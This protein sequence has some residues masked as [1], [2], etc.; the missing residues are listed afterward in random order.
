ML[1]FELSDLGAVVEIKLLIE[2]GLGVPWFFDVE[3]W[4]SHV[5]SYYWEEF[6]SVECDCESFVI[7][8]GEVLCSSGVDERVGWEG[9]FK[10]HLVIVKIVFKTEGIVRDS[11]LFYYINW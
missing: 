1:G 5:E 10:T 3:S 8:K 4:A 11:L 7:V 2:L 9:G 6:D